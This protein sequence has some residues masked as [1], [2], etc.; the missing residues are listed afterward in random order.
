MN[1]KR[2]PQAVRPAAENAPTVSKAEATTENAPESSLLVSVTV[3]GRATRTHTVSTSDVLRC[4]R[5]G[6]GWLGRGIEVYDVSDEVQK[7]RALYA[8]THAKV[9]AENG[10]P[11]KARKAAKNAVTELK[12]ALPLILWS[13]VF[14][15]REQPIRSPRVGAPPLGSVSRGAPP[16]QTRPSIRARRRRYSG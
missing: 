11:E 6:G 4:M 12:L 16:Y 10:D 7:I 5:S 15:N 8:R 1:T 9:L 14:A 2:E 13:A 3:S